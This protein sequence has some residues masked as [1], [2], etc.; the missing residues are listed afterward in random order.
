[1]I[2]IKFK[3]IAFACL[4]AVFVLICM[5]VK[6]RW[7][8]ENIYWVINSAEEIAGNEPYCIQVNGGIDYKEALALSDLSG[9]NMRGA[10][11]GNYH[12]I[13]VI[14]DVSKPKLLNWSY[15]RKSF[16]SDVYGNPAIF[17]LPQKHFAKVLTNTPKSKP[18]K[19]GF[20]YSGM[21]FSIPSNARSFTHGVN[22]LGFSFNDVRGEITPDMHALISVDFESSGVM[23]GWIY[24]QNSPNHIV[25]DDGEV[26]GLKKQNTWYFGSGE[27]RKKAN[28]P[29]HI[30]YYQESNTQVV[31]T[32]IACPN[33]LR[34]ECMHTFQRDGW[35]YTF[36]YKPTH[37]SEWK[38]LEE[39][40]VKLTNSYIVSK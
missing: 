30:Q 29:E 10:E 5:W 8:E 24:R 17:C 21:K 6:A 37:V 35:T 20:V 3:Y 25:E 27:R 31:S 32:L 33:D 23:Q 11:L 7:A 16:L 36:K 18:K 28:D 39:R 26:Y 34:G 40:V 15:N 19:L 1:M 13:L 14:G 12:A 4:I 9:N 2:L 38:R 22:H